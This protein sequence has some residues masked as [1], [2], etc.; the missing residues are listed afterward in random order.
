MILKA[1]INGEDV[2]AFRREDGTYFFQVSQML[3]AAGLSIV[4]NTV[5]NNADPARFVKAPIGGPGHMAWFGDIAGYREYIGYQRKRNLSLCYPTVT[6]RDLAVL[7]G[8]LR[9]C[10]SWIEQQEA[11]RQEAAIVPADAVPDAMEAPPEKAVDGEPMPEAGGPPEEE[12]A[13]EPDPAYGQ[14]D[15]G[16]SVPPSMGRAGIAGA[17]K[18]GAA[19]LAVSGLV[20]IAMRRR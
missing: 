5:R 2:R 20:L 19:L 8:C 18:I 7:E 16:A 14:G 15:P 1:K 6:G 12:G 17:I 13:G 4:V 9:S 11:A 3:Y 10:E